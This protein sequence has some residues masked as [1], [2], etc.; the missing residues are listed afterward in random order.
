MH[1][2]T[3]NTW[4]GEG[5]YTKRLGAMATGLAALSPDIVTL[6]E[7]LAAPAVGYDTAGHLAA[8]LHM[9]VARLPLRHKPRLVE[10]RTVDSTSGLAVLSRWPIRAQRSVPLTSDPRDGER[11]ALTAEIAMP[12]RSITI[13]CLHLTHLADGKELR[14]TQWREVAAA[15][16]G[17]GSAIVAG[18]FNAS[19]AAFDLHGFTDSRQAC[20]KPETPTAIYES[21]PVCIDHVLSKELRATGWH[22][23]LGDVPLGCDVLPSDHVAV[24]VDFALD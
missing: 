6:Q 20:G 4:K 8:A 12:E 21:E 13:A 18:D 9:T 16:S 17:P 3:L 22:T 1:L 2:V 15:M 5:T 7:V 19:V 23:A 24:M 14:R 11:A 10:G